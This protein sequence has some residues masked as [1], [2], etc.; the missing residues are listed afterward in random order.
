MRQLFAWTLVLALAIFAAGCGGDA[1]KDGAQGPAGAN[2]KDGAAGTVGKDGVPGTPGKDGVDGLAGK[3]GAAG[4]AGAAGDKGDK[5]DTGAAG[6]D[7]KDGT[8][9]KDWEPA[10]YA[11]SAVC[12]ACHSGHAAAFAKMGHGYKLTKVVNGQA[13]VFPF[14]SITGGV[15][16][17]LPKQTHW[18]PAGGGGAG[19]WV[20]GAP[21]TWNDVSYV[22][23]GFAW[24][25]RF[26]DKEGYI[27]T[28]A[29]DGA[30]KNP[31]QWL[32]ANAELAKTAQYTNYETNY[33]KT[34]AG[35]RKPYDCGSCH[36]TG[37][38][39]CPIGDASCKRQDDLPGMAG[40]FAEPGVQC[41]ACHGPGSQHIAAPY[42]VSMVIERDAELCGKCHRRDEVEVVDAKGGFIEHREQFEQTFAS[43]KVT[44]D[45]I[46]CHNPHKSSMFS[47][48]A[49]NPGK[50]IR[51]NCQTCHVNYDKNQNSATMASMVACID[52]HMPKIAKS[53]W[54]DAA[55]FKG[56]GRAHFFHINTDA[57]QKQ[58]TPNGLASNPYVSLDWACK[59][60]HRAGGTASVKT[61]VELET[62]A[63]N[64]H[65]GTF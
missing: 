7:G 11:G 62:E 51:H 34:N 14:D 36:T 29:D 4:A 41:E 17:T 48:P 2:G 5:G 8:D 65:G 61:D 59:S 57:D 39:P 43:K 53:S 26:V 63:V 19:A 55:K 28:S 32:F 58:F 52:C 60:C 9:G 54:G 35:K 49:V 40:S 23:G 56:D 46:D 31:T 18:D 24:K 45:C 30:V 10:S 22:I 27:V 3:D 20:E 6:A 1:G 37:W 15:P 21:Y 38:I 42:Q 44:M 47:D 64:Y 50:G 25:L 16:A 13:P 12:S 33:E